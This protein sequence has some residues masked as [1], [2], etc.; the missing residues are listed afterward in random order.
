MNSR[1]IVDG[2]DDNEYERATKVPSRRVRTRN[3]IKHEARR[4]LLGC[5][6]REYRSITLN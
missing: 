1:I 5:E 3:K 2:D 6:R 4:G